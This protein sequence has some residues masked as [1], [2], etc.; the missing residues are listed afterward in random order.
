MRDSYQRYGEV[1][2]Y[3]EYLQA[4]RTSRLDLSTI[5][6]SLELS[7]SQ[8][9]PNQRYKHLSVST[10]GA[11]W[12]SHY[13]ISVRSQLYDQLLN[14]WKCVEVKISR[15]LLQNSTSHEI[16]LHIARNIYKALM[17]EN[18]ASQLESWSWTESSVD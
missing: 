9:F 15:Q 16:S 4:K 11:D 6:N 8:G 3:E 2:S 7:I 12:L 17:I 14:K 1:T 18:Q 5:L 10:G 13:L